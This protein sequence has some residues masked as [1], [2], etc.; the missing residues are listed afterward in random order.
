MKITVENRPQ[1]Y[2]PILSIEAETPEDKRELLK[3]SKQAEEAQY[4]GIMHGMSGTGSAC[5]GQY[6]KEGAIHLSFV[7]RLGGPR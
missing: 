4:I 7:V 5:G 3:I 1:D 6:D 2:Q